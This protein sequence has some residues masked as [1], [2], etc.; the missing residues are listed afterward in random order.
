MI[1]HCAV[2]SA[3]VFLQETFPVGLVHQ[4]SSGVIEEGSVGQDV[5]LFIGQGHSQVGFL[6][7]RPQKSEKIKTDH[8]N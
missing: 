7:A 2:F 3:E 1:T 4:T 5:V 8:T 6:S